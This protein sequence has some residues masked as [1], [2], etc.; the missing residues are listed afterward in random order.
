MK[1]EKKYHTVGIVPKS[2]LIKEGMAMT[3]NKPS[4][5]KYQY[6]FYFL[7]IKHPT[8]KKK[9]DLIET[10]DTKPFSWHVF[11]MGIKFFISMM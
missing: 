9:P 3:K 1:N 5:N 11:T 4:C 10:G 7:I 2:N 6:F 8:E